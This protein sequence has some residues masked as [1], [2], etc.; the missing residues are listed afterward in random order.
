MAKKIVI[1]TLFLV[2]VLLSSCDREKKGF[3]GGDYQVRLSCNNAIEWHLYFSSS[4][5]TGRMYQISGLKSLA[6][7]ST[8]VSFRYS[9]S[10]DFITFYDMEQLRWKDDSGAYS[11][12]LK[13]CRIVRGYKYGNFY[14]SNRLDF[15]ED[16]YEAFNGTYSM[17][18]HIDAIECGSWYASW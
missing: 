6:N 9:V 4:E 1:L 17:W 11:L 2:V 12:L 15:S 8:G 18:L 7:A 5:G 16:G 13:R 14:G 10:G 3:Y